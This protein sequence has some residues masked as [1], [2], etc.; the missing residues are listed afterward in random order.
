MPTSGNDPRVEQAIAVLNTGTQRQD[1][2]TDQLH[3]VMAL[4][5][6]AG[7]YDAHEL[8]KRTLDK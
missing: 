7:C 8:I 5:V 1:S 3:D 4:A 2:T 6:A